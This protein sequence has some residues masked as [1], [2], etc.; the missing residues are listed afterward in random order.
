MAENLNIKENPIVCVTL[1]EIA[2]KDPEVEFIRNEKATTSNTARLVQLLL[3]YCDKHELEYLQM[4]RGCDIPAMLV[5]KKIP[6][7]QL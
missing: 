4:V 1:E 2:K 5:A 7:I 3:E 6:F